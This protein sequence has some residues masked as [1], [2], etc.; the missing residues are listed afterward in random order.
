[1]LSKKFLYVFDNG[2]G[3]FTK[4]QASLYLREGALPV[5]C[6]SRSLPYAFREKVEIELYTLTQSQVLE[7]VEFSDWTTPLVAAF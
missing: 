3:K 7:T 5:Y 2:M 6:R 4:G 1:M